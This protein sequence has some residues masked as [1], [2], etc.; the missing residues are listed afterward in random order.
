VEVV[1]EG[2]PREILKK[3]RERMVSLAVHRVLFEPLL[4]GGT[5]WH[6]RPVGTRRGPVPVSTHRVQ[7]E[8]GV[9]PEQLTDRSDQVC[10]Q[11]VRCLELLVAVRVLRTAALEGVPLRARLI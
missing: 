8:M 10:I 4:H 7:E 9:E 1:D 2:V 5:V 11:G 3:S 6:R